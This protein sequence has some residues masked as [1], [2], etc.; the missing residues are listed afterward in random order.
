MSH[1]YTHKA[2]DTNT[3]LQ[4]QIQIQNGQVAGI[5]AAGIF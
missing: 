5:Q 3:Q 4:I 2:T 1:R